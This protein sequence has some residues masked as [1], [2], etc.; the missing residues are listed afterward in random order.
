MLK[1]EQS[2]YRS[3][4]KKCPTCNKDFEPLTIKGIK[5]KHCLKCIKSIKLVPSSARQQ[6][7]LLIN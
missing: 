6:N 2:L 5:L 3:T 1:K 7:E 4:S